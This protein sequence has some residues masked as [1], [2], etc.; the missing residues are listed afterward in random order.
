MDTI[1]SFLSV[2]VLLIMLAATLD[3]V[4]N[5]MLVKSDGFRRRWVG[6]GAIVLVGMAFLALSFA[7]RGMDLAVAYAMWGGFGILGTS[8]GGWFFFGQG[9]KPCA[10]CGI[11]LLL[12]GMAVLHAS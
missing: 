5:L 10:W 3:V 2:Y 6:L 8:L 7:V 1:F 9:L 11:A 12:T 4:A